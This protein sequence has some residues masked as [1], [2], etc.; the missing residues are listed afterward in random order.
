MK[1]F[2]KGSDRA[3]LELYIEKKNIPIEEEV[4]SYGVGLRSHQAVSFPN[5]LL[6]KSHYNRKSS[7]HKCTVG[8]DQ[9]Y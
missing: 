5:S 4:A 9:R 6:S 3:Y 8:T 7:V 2:F 1:V